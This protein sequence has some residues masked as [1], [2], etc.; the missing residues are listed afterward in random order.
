MHEDEITLTEEE[1]DNIRLSLPITLNNEDILMVV[2]SILLQYI[3]K[4]DEATAVLKDCIDNVPNAYHYNV[5][6][7]NRMH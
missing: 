6:I 4:E 2:L 5:D 1:W 7:K 3:D